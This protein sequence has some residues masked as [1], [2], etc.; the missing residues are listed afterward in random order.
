MPSKHKPRHSGPEPAPMHRVTVVAHTVGRYSVAECS[1][2]IPAVDIAH[3]RRAGI[4]EAHRRSPEPLP[5][6]RPFVRESW[7]YSSA[8]AI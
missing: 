8:V 7:P 6:W 4:A 3:A 1:I 5:P 2:E